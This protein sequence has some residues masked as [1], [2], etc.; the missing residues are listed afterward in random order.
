MS[1][2]FHYVRQQKGHSA[3]KHI[4]F[5]G[6]LLWIPSIYYAISKNHYYHL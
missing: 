6:L 1:K 2:D 5:G 3:I 4:L